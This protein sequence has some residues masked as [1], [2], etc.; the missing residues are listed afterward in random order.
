MTHPVGEKRPNAWGLYDMHGNVYQWCA[1]WYS[2]NFYGQSPSSNP[3]GPATGPS[4]VL[5]GGTWFDMPSSCR[6]A[7]RT[8]HAP[9]FRTHYYGFRVVA[10][11]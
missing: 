5:R 9:A 7:F 4:H 3:S 1:D 10:E 11:R 8:C 2:K 6:S